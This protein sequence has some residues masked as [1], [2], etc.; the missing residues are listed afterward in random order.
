MPEQ[1]DERPIILPGELP[2]PLELGDFL[3]IEASQEVQKED[4]GVDDDPARPVPLDQPEEVVLHA[5]R[6]LIERTC[7]VSADTSNTLYSR[8]RFSPPRASMTGFVGTG[9][10]KPIVTSQYWSS[11][12]SRTSSSRTSRRSLP[13]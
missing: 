13:S 12:D 10:V 2:G 7:P 5:S 11:S 9:R 1:Q 4:V 8:L 6:M 3:R